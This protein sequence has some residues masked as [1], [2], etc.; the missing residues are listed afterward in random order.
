M[1]IVSVELDPKQSVKRDFNRKYD[2]KKKD[3]VGDFDEEYDTKINELIKKIE[4]ITGVSVVNNKKN[5]DYDFL[6]NL[7]QK[8]LKK[9]KNDK[10]FQYYALLDDIS[11]C[12]SS[13]YLY[14]YSKNKQFI[15]SQLY[16]VDTSMDLN[17]FIINSW[18]RFIHIR[19]PTV[20]I[21]DEY[22][23]WMRSHNLDFEKL[24]NTN[25]VVV[26]NPS[27]KKMVND[28]TKINY[29][30]TD[31]KDDE[32]NVSH[33]LYFLDDIA[34]HFKDRVVDSMYDVRIKTIYLQKFIES[35]RQ[36]LS[37]RKD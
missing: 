16:P 9:Y 23:K 15:Y 30:K 3:T 34:R 12:V 2:N 4:S 6:Y 7:R 10:R 5:D 19:F 13:E 31:F 25:N 1:S 21:I 11:N 27:I 14:G 26:L 8:E 37:K 18:F 36:F 17:V 20:L 29:F 22:F 32:E 35:F 33:N 24:N 28:S